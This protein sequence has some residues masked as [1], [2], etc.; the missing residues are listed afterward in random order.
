MGRDD[1]YNIIIYHILKHTITS[2]TIM[3]N[4]EIQIAKE[5]TKEEEEQSKI[6]DKKKKNK[7]MQKT[8]QQPIVD[9][10]K[11]RDQG[12]AKPKILLLLPTRGT[13]YNLIMKL[14]QCFD[15]NKNIII[16]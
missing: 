10:I 11:Y 5:R 7:K 3:Y 15:N 4:N 8:I 6:K 14:I 16:R 13:C 2:N 1:M 12:Y 9:P